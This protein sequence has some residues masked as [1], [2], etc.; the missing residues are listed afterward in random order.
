VAIIRFFNKFLRKKQAKFVSS[1]LVEKPD[2]GHLMAETCSLL[3]M[4]YH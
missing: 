1:K 2:D 4:A 3:S